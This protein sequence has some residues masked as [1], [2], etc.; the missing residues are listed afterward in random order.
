MADVPASAPSS[1]RCVVPWLVGEHLRSDGSFYGRFEATA[2]VRGRGLHRTRHPGQPV[3][4]RVRP[5]PVGHRPARLGDLDVRGLRDVR[6]PASAE[7]GRRSS[8]SALV[9]NMSLT[10]ND[11]LGYLV[12]YSVA[13]MLLLIRFHALDEQAEWLRRRIGDPTA[14]SGIY[15]RGGSVF[16]V[17][18]GRRVAPAHDGRR[19]GAAGRGLGRRQRQRRRGLAL[20][21]QVPAGRRELPQPRQR[22]RGGHARSAG[23]GSSD[24]RVYVTIQLSPDEDED[25][26]WRASHVRHGSTSTA[27]P[28]AR[29]PTSRSRP[30]IRCSTA[31][32]RTWPTPS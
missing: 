25:F 3:H 22:V 18:R 20:A 5:P 14:I 9:I 21:G 19:L 4:Q 11:Q 27:G 12:L 6:A 23:S 29:R 7:C 10:T 13:A 31:R 1:P 24:D 17:A 26:Y 32:W 16:I 8:A 15:L 30:A 28:R 2:D